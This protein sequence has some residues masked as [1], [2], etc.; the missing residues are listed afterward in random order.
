MTIDICTAGS[1]GG[2]PIEGRGGA[3][4]GGDAS[5]SILKDILEGAGTVGVPL[6]TFYALLTVGES[7][8][9]ADMGAG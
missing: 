8:G 5:G 4:S 3:K 9:M 6:V 1:G 2:S 7:A